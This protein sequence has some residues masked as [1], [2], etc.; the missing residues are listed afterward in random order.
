MT[1]VLVTGASGQVG[2]AFLA[3]AA[4]NKV[5]VV[6]PAR[7]ELDL[8]NPAS[9]RA[10]M[11]ENRFDAVV[12]CAAYTAVDKAE[13]EQELAQAINATGPGLLAAAA[14]GQGAQFI[15]V[16]TD[17]VFDGSKSGAY[18]EDDELAPLGAYGAS[19]L[20]GEAAVRAAHPDDAI[21]RT[22][23]VLSPGGANFLNTMIRL[24]GERDEVGVVNDQ[25][26]CP[27]SAADIAHALHLMVRGGKAGTWHFVNDGTASW[28]NLARFIFDHMRA[29]GIKAPAC[30]AISTAD[31]PTPARRPANSVLSW[32]KFSADFGYKPRFWQD[33]VNEILQERF[34]PR[35]D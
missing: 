15:H 31:Y 2:G 23:W 24:A 28:Y 33:A 16:S 4:L 7:A 3:Q 19:K 6:A 25:I 9:I 20:A 17:Y 1:R 11:A 30:K 29:R 5:D 18:V 32:A 12:N 21:L 22:A 10:F 35:K 13:S 14:K 27:T 26:G 8:A 34:A